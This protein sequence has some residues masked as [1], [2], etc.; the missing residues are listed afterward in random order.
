MTFPI[1]KDKKLDTTEIFPFPLD[2]VINWNDNQ[3]TVL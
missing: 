3:N 2:L 1:K